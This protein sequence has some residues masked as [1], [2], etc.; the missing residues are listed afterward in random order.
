M[1]ALPEASWKKKLQLNYNAILNL[2]HI[3]ATFQT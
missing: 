3:I 1:D 2:E